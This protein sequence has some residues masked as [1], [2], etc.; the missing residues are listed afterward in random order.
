M[1]V[2][3]FTLSLFCLAFVI[4]L[5]VWRIHL[6]TRQIKTLV[7][8]F[9]VILIL[10]ILALWLFPPSFRFLQLSG[11]E[12]FWEYIHIYLFFV[13]LTLAYMITYTAIEADSPSL[14]LIMKVSEAGSEGLDSK[15]LEQM[16]SDD[17][18]V[19]PRLEDLV[20]DKMA[21]INGNRYFLTAKGVLM[22]R[23]FLYYRKLLGA[24]KGG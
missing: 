9:I 20:L 8:L 2:L 10:G 17:I 7:Q 21:Y 5:I 22:V 13:S 19:I 12:S 1:K 4:H 14:V 23:I 6:P 16:M 11:P 18:L 24:P 15:K 3:V